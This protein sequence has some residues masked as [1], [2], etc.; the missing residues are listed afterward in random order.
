MLVCNSRWVLIF[1]GWKRG[2]SF[3]GQSQ[4]DAM[5][6]QIRLKDFRHCIENRSNDHKDNDKAKAMAKDKNKGYLHGLLG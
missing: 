3:A 6:N 1:F 2:V 4:S 5:Q